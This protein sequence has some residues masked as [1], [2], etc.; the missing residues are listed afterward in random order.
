VHLVCKEARVI[1]GSKGGQEILELLETTGT[2]A[3]REIQA[4]LVR[5]DH[6]AIRVTREL[7]AV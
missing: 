3:R 1:L 7:R 2:Q 5:L 6:R 4:T